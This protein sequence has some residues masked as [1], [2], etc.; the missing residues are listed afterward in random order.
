MSNKEIQIQSESFHLHVNQAENQE[1]TSRSFTQSV[2]LRQCLRQNENRGKRGGELILMVVGAADTVI[3][4][5][6][7]KV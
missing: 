6:E 4:E 3:V 5:S 7:P 2:P 1:H